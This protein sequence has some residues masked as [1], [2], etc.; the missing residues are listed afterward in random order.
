M[1]VSADDLS[2]INN[3]YNRSLVLKI[4]LSTLSFPMKRRENLRET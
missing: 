3:R 4:Y 2:L 1:P